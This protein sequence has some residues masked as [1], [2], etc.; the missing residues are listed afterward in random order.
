MMGA[1]VLREAEP[2]T[3]Q[4][5]FLFTDELTEVDSSLIKEFERSTKC[6]VRIVFLTAEEYLIK[7]GK[8]R[9]NTGADVLWFSNDSVREKLYQSN[10]LLAIDNKDWN[11]LEGEF[12]VKHKLWFPICHDPLVLTKPKDS[13]DCVNIN[14]NTWHK[15]DSASPKYV[16]PW[17]LSKYA[18]SIEKTALKGVL[19]PNKDR[20]IANEYIWSLSSLTKKY[21]EVDTTFNK[22]KYY[23]KQLI[24]VNKTHIT[25]LNCMY[26]AKYARNRKNGNLLINWLVNRHKQIAS[27]RNE[28]SCT[29]DTPPSYTIQQLSLL[30]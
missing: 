17:I 24:S 25:Q 11:N 1:C 19:L 16:Y 4:E 27:S 8:D 30:F 15:K 6:N 12:Y 3:K 28:L 10:S 7:V 23:C 5:V 18:Y 20:K 9:F 26:L 21:I 13:T 2:S 22:N 29:K 14:F